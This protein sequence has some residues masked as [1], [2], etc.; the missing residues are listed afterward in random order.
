MNVLYISYDG[1]TDPLGQS[2]IIPYLTGL[3]QKGHSITVLATEK[4]HPF[5][6]QNL[7][8]LSVL[9]KYNIKWVPVNYTKYPPV[10][11]GVWNVFKLKRRAIS[12][13]KQQDITVVHCRSYVS[14][15]VG[16]YLK[17]KFHTKFIFDMR[18]FWADERLEGNIWNRN[19]IL[20]RYIYKY[21]KKKEKDFLIHA[22]HVICLTENSKKE[23]LSWNNIPGQ[24][25]KV[26]VIPCCADLRHFSKEN[27][28]TWIQNELKDDLRITN[29]DFILS[30]LGSIGTWYMLDEM[31]QFFKRLLIKK[32]TAKFLF[33]TTESRELIIRAVKKNEVPPD[34]VIIQKSAREEVPVLLSLSK[35][36]VFFIKPVFSKKA[37]SPT[38]MGEVL[39]MG[40]P[41]ICN[42]NIGDVDSI[43]KESGC[44]IL[45]DNFGDEYYDKAIDKIDN[46]LLINKDKVISTAE[47]YF[48][49]EKAISIY[50][51]VYQEVMK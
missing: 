2:Q 46:L 29:D 8:I 28:N 27:I 32:P 49:L 16:I 12:I 5:A 21:F 48:S 34:R 4:K 43:I 41:V 13:C 15:L 22:D 30:Y 10:L 24:P 23:I 20:Y 44:G 37:S 36:S 45:V 39:S 38:K 18:G 33:I 17:S 14:S 6:Q 47:K 26:E 19:N 42:S 35:L 7:K 11:S 51:K 40:I 25:V 31:L 3:A 1:L 50:N 9:Q